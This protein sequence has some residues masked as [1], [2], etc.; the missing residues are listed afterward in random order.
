M[1]PSMD[2]SA[3]SPNIAVPLRE[4]RRKLTSP[5]LSECAYERPLWRNCDIKQP[6][7]MVGESGAFDGQDDQSL[8]SG[9]GK[10]GD[11][12]NL[13]VPRLK[14]ERGHVLHLHVLEFLHHQAVS[15]R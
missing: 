4:H 7:F 9:D 15:N 12:S 2:M 8:L 14:R 6:L 1:V 13:G 3:R 5:T 10:C 11:L